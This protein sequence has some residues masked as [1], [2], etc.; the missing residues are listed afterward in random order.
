MM[1]FGFKIS[2]INIGEWFDPECGTVN[3][4]LYGVLTFVSFT[5]MCFCLRHC[6]QH[7]GEPK[8]SAIFS[9]LGAIFSIYV[10]FVVG[11]KRVRALNKSAWL[12][13]SYFLTPLNFFVFLYLIGAERKEIEHDTEQ[14]EQSELEDAP[15]NPSNVKEVPQPSVKHNIQKRRTVE[16]N[17]QDLVFKEVPV[18]I[19]NV[20]KPSVPKPVDTKSEVENKKK[21]R[22]SKFVLTEVSLENYL[23][24]RPDGSTLESNQTSQKLNNQT[25]SGNE[26]S[27][28][29]FHSASQKE[30]FLEE[31]YSRKRNQKEFKTIKATDLSDISVGE[32]NAEISDRF[33]SDTDKNSSDLKSSVKIKKEVPSELIQNE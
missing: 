23:V 8:I 18:K 33:Q 31:H 11:I 7:Y 9:L 3:G 21:S 32:N 12:L 5:L 25:H 17:L 24:G 13:L 15:L 10:L 19:E 29:E 4:A 16:E 6:F 1:K 28:V 22:K 27:P 14:S 2:K 30:I 20:S 26:E